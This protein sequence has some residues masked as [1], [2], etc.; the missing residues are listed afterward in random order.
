MPSRLAAGGTNRVAKC[1]HRNYG[2]I[3][4]L[5]P[6]LIAFAAALCLGGPASSQEAVDTPKLLL[7]PQRLRR[8][9]RDHSRQTVRW[10]NFENR[11][12]NVADSPERGFELALY[13]AVT[14]DEKQGREA[15]DWALAHKCEQRQVALV[16]NWCGRL[17]SEEHKRALSAAT[18]QAAAPASIAA[19]DAL[20]SA[21]SRAE[22]SNQASAPW[23]G[24]LSDLQTGRF[25]DPEILYASL[26]YLLTVRTL[27]H[28]DLR[29]DDPK[30]FSGLPVEFLLSLKPAQVQHPDWKTHVA[31]LALVALDPNLESSQFLQGWALEDAQML[32]EGPGVAYEFLW[33][34]PYL[35]GVGYENL[36]TWTYD[37][38]GRLFARRSWDVDTCWIGISAS[39]LQQ[40]NC[41]SGWQNVAE[42]FGHLTLIPMSAT[43]VAVP[44]RKTNADVVILW[45]LQPHQRLFYYSAEKKEPLESDA[46][47]MSRLPE[48]VEGDVCTSLDKLKRP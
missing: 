37:S 23:K 2:R 45:K 35:P 12:N 48:N 39:G 36:D 20:F 38:N 21:V 13:Y 43:C 44:H 3:H 9:E 26:E 41:P 30:L 7:T 40:Q 24:I 27:T 46:A 47:G 22:D 10:T 11:V 14:H 25:T 8:L 19:R 32:R 29:Q 4:G 16:L 34:D 31:A 1:L 28:T 33:A 15:V 6:F 17:L 18:C 5:R 42:R